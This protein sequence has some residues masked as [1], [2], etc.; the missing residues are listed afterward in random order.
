M[1]Q[2]AIKQCPKQTVPHIH[3]RERSERKKERSNTRKWFYNHYLKQVTNET[4][5]IVVLA[6]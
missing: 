4:Y 1:N 5:G 3:T 6:L 2:A